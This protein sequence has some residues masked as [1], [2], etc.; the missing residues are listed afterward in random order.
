MTKIG[1]MT[2]EELDEALAAI[3]RRAKEL[4][5]AGVVG[6]IAIGDIEFELAGPDEAP[7]QAVTSP[8]GDDGRGSPIDDPETY[9]G[10]VPSRRQPRMMP[11]EHEE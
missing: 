5:D 7:L 8:A 2:A 9:G 1:D 6:Q 11:H 10:A 3:A 4:R